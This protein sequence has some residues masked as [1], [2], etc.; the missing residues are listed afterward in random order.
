[1][2][3]VNVATGQPGAAIKIAVAGAI[4][5]TPNGATAHVARRGSGSVTPIRGGDRCGAE[6]DSGREGT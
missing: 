1:V 2:I 4:A 3:P 5:I 6:V